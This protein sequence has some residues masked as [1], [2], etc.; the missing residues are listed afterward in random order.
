MHVC[1]VLCED[2]KYKFPATMD[3][4]H[5]I[6]CRRAGRSGGEKWYNN[7]TD[8]RRRNLF[9]FPIL[10]TFFLVFFFFWLKCFFIEDSLGDKVFGLRS[11]V[12]AFFIFNIGLLMVSNG[13]WGF[14]G[15]RGT[16]SPSTYIHCIYIMYI[17]DEWVPVVSPA[18]MSV[19]GQYGPGAFGDNRLRL[20]N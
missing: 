4:S 2:G 18:K 1:H 11:F 8:T 20:I 5:Y 16:N 15:T 6:Y 19:F 17:Y 7:A 14:C 13:E 10:H 9:G 12:R 3:L